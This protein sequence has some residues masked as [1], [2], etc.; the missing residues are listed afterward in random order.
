MITIRKQANLSTEASFNTEVLLDGVVHLVRSLC[1]N[2][3][4]YER[5]EIATYEF[6]HF[7]EVFAG[8]R[9]IGVRFDDVLQR[10]EDKFL[11][12]DS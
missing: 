8:I 7:I 11:V 2:S 4:I 1:R 5:K 6:L 3:A 9:Y 12:V 10:Q